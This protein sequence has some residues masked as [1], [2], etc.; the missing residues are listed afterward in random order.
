MTIVKLLAKKG[1][2]R[3]LFRLC[4][5]HKFDTQ[6]DI[7][8]Y[9]RE[10]GSFEAL[11]GCTPEDI[12]ELENLIEANLIR[13][14][15]QWQISRELL[16]TNCMIQSADHLLKEKL[17]PEKQLQVLLSSFSIFG[18]TD[19]L[20]PAV[21]GEMM[22]IT[23]RSVLRLRKLAMGGILAGFRSLQNLKEDL[24]S[25]YE[26][27]I[28]SELI[29]IDEAWAQRINT[30][31]D[32]RFSPQFLGFLFGINLQEKFVSFGRPEEVLAG[33]YLGIRHLWKDFYLV[34][35][36]LAAALDIEAFVVESY[37]LKHLGGIRSLNFNTFVSHFIRSGH[38][39]E[40]E[41]LVSLAAEILF[42]ELGLRVVKGKLMFPPRKQFLLCE[43]A[44][45]ALKLL[46][47]PSRLEVIRR[48]VEE[49]HPGIV[50]DSN[51]FDLVLLEKWG[52]TGYQGLYGLKKWFQK[53]KLKQQDPALLEELS[54]AQPKKTGDYWKLHWN[55]MFEELE[56]FTDAYDRLPEIDGP[57]QEKK[58]FNWLKRQMVDSRKGRLDPRQLE[59]YKAFRLRFPVKSGSYWKRLW[60]NSFQDLTEFSQTHG[61]P[62]RRSGPQEEFKLYRWLIAQKVLMKKG[63][64][65][66]R[67]KTL[68][69]DFSESYPLRPPKPRW[70]VSFQKL[71]RFAEA[72]S[73]LPSQNAE[74]EEERAL[75]F[76]WLR[77]L[78]R[79]N[80]GELNSRQQG[81]LKD[82]KRRYP[83]NSTHNRE[84]WDRRLSELRTYVEAHGLP[85]GHKCT[86]LAKTLRSWLIIQR[87]RMNKG[88]LNARQQKL[89]KE[90]D[91]QYVVPVDRK[92]EWINR[93]KEL[94]NFCESHCRLPKVE[95]QSEAAS[96]RWL[97]TQRYNMK[98]KML[99]NFQQQKLLDLMERYPVRSA[100]YHKVFWYDKFEELERFAET[101]SRLPEASKNKEQAL[102]KWFRT[103]Q[104][105]GRSGKLDS[106]Q[107]S[108]LKDLVTRFPVVNK[109]DQY[110]EARLK[111]L[112][113]FVNKYGRLPKSKAPVKESS[114]YSWFLRQQKRR[115]QGELEVQQSLLIKNLANRYRREAPDWEE[116]FEEVREFAETHLRIPKRTATDE[117]ERALNHWFQGQKERLRKG[118]LDEEQQELVKDL[119]ARYGTGPGRRKPVMIPGSPD[120]AEV[121]D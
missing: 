76:F 101:H 46:G 99:D 19:T 105:R 73:R 42:R 48:K 117:E 120:L 121:E 102:Y 85:K 93:F 83:Y 12:A 87:V 70:E 108:R 15:L 28:S 17:L 94:E 113:K 82:L 11:E 107:R 91:A 22:E 43:Y 18:G 20:T 44:E 75:N 51:R 55:Q 21:L 30:R 1:I 114:L 116:R 54:A 39:T 56:A 35:K 106:I 60:D 23:A 79:M 78:D 61:R 115:E 24:Q 5:L 50:V 67:Q 118:R 104:R 100:V 32:T 69:R 80:Q 45:E 8:A 74:D 10:H 37:R 103:Q 33:N 98:K 92:A 59:K 58:L 47:K 95:I 81:L 77:Q 96:Y 3:Q 89:L 9:F 64:L 27:D 71:R 88:E 57:V 41:V 31:W 7:E 53:G 68:L 2:S 36:D 26:L 6:A 66:L 29:H 25:N 84:K 119:V 111:D 110:W 63:E 14:S 97:M 34:R 13:L 62:P 40:P 112:Q 49:L 109:V 4:R 72:Y 86:G 90:F 52:F 16:R 65:N 38:N